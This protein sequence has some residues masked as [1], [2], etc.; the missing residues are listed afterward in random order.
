MARFIVF[1]WNRT[2]NRTLFPNDTYFAVLL[3]FPCIAGA[4]YALADPLTVLGVSLKV[5]VAKHFRMA[6][7]HDQHVVSDPPDTVII[8][9]T[10]EGGCTPVFQL[11][12]QDDGSL[13]AVPRTCYED[14]GSYCIVIGRWQNFRST[15]PVDA[16]TWKL[17][18][19][20]LDT[21]NL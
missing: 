19:L 13:S 4:F 18:V 12:F 17:V 6:L 5:R 9:D 10:K 1:Y 16:K 8:E 14:G 7:V 11:E 20:V 3:F 21:D 15:S 2:R